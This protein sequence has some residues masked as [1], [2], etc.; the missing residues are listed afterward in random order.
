MPPSSSRV[1]LRGLSISQIQ[2]CIP[3]WWKQSPKELG[4][5]SNHPI[6]E[7]GTTNNESM[8]D[9]LLN[10]LKDFTKQGHLSKAFKVFSQIQ[11]HGFS[12][13]DDVIEHSIS[14]LVLSCSNLKSFMQGK[15]LHAQIISLGFD[16]HPI[17]V[18]R[19]VTFYSSFN[20][21]SD[22]HT[23]LEQSSV[24][25]PLPWNILISSYVENE[26][27][28]EALSA[29]KKMVSKGIRPDN[30]TYPSVLKACSATW[31]L[32]FGKEVHKSIDASGSRWNLFVHNS[33]V[34]MY[35][36]LGELDVAQRLFDSMMERDSVSWNA[37]INGYASKG[38]WKETFELF[39][40]MRVEAVEVNI[41]T[42]NT[43]IGLCMKI[44]NFKGALELLSQMRRCG[45]HLDAVAMSN[46]LGACSH[47]G[48]IKLGTEIH[49]SAI[50][51]CCDGIDNVRNALITM[52]CRCKDLRHA[53]TLFQ[54][55]EVK[56]MIN[57]NSMLSGYCHMDCFEEASIL[58]RKMMLSGIT[59]NYVTIASILP[60]CA[61]EAKL[62]HGKEI[63]CYIVRREEF[64][65]YLLLWNAL[66]DMYTR[67]KGNAS[68]ICLL[69]DGLTEQ[70]K[71]SHF[72]AVK[73][74]CS[75]DG[76]LEDID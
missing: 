48:A 2:R 47:I 71:D 64:K 33:L 24:M 35:G 4:V 22:A 36:K 41:L 20:I 54:S 61:R 44:G 10:S 72:D 27:F 8:L 76:L 19:L 37:M 45:L 65:D 17:L 3:K 13:G 26:L 5:E 63:H 60:L 23:A 70:M 56:S 66:V 74:F 6:V 75:E 39:E 30:F 50:R 25:Q 57:W 34:S 42:W 68:E 55:I 73:P 43:L 62:R 40:K 53:N 51:G 49:G 9:I 14:S 7:L 38:M 32:S 31:N 18:P 52:Y 1:I 16:Q 69:L 15:Q 46:G 67:S 21:L 28:E 11:L 29:Y 59:P 12:T 58:F